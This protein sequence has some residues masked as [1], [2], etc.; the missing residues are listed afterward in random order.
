VTDRISKLQR[1]LDLLAYLAARRFPVSFEQ[2]RDAVP[3]YA[4]DLHANE[5]DHESMRRKFERDKKELKALG[6]PI[7]TQD[8]GDAG[9]LEA[10]GYRLGPGSFRLPYLRLLEEAGQ[11]GARPPVT[12]APGGFPLTRDEAGSVTAG[13]LALS[14][15]PGFPLAEQARAAFRKLAFDLDPDVVGDT[16][17][18]YA[19]DPEVAATAETLRSLS[20]AL[21]SRK[22]VRMRYRSMGRDAEEDRSVEPYGL[23]F[24]HGRWYLVAGDEKRGEPRMF[25]VGRMS[26]VELNRARPGSPDFDVPDDFDLSAWSGRSAW[27]MGGDPEGAVEA[28]VLF[29]F[30]RSL[31]AERNAHGRL[32]EEHEDGAQ[33]RR[34]TVH[35]RDPFL[36]W[37]LS[38]A[39]DARVTGPDAFRDAFHALA[40]AALARYEGPGRG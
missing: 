27:E 21:L 40:R 22:R 16:P 20:H 14:S 17:V 30:P 5:T 8:L 31:W 12:P 29:S 23:L 13:L 4:L 37:V 25:R 26:D 3:G 7:E 28:E 38:M 18:V 33:L 9:E 6:I 36:R 24:Q 1:W 34:F 32:L 15:V 35:R 10:L 11:E 19:T 2:L 39:G